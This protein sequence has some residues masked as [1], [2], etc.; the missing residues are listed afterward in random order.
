MLIFVQSTWLRVN[1]SFRKKQNNLNVK[2]FTEKFFCIKYHLFLVGI[3]EYSGMLI[4][5]KKQERWSADDAK[6][7]GKLLADV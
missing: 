1:I 3:K 4:A 2:I 7:S 6:I 5:C